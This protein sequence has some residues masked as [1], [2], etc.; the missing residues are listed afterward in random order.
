M[1][2][3]RSA[4]WALRECDVTPEAAYRSRRD[5]MAAGGALAASAALAGCARG[6]EPDGAG[7]DGAGQDGDGQDGLGGLDFATT[8]Y[9]VDGALTPEAFATGYN[10][11]YEFGTGKTDPAR[12]ARAMTTDPWS[13]TVEGLCEKP[14]TYALEDVVDFAALE[15]RIYRLRCVEAWSMVIPWI[16][17]PLADVLAPFAPRADARYVAFET[18]VNRDEM[19]GVRQWPPILDWPYVE[20]LRMDEAMNPLA[21]IAVGLYGRVLPNQ[22]G[23]PLRLVVPWKYGF[24]SIKSITKIRFVAEQ[25]PTSWSTSIPNEYGFYSNVNPEVSHP[26]W[27]QDSERVIGGRPGERRATDMFNGYAQEVAHLYAGMDLSV[28]Y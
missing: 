14:G 23:A 6:D 27:R 20:G 13:V 7:Q 10:N 19:R 5:I 12:Y 17:V 24:K 9:R 2:I 3:R 4:R 16:G 28:F 25:P 1:F 15:E 22:N 11:F 21:F 18:H 8:D 26:R